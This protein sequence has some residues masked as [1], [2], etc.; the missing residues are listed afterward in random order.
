MDLNSNEKKIKT[1]V[2]VSCILVSFVIFTAVKSC[3]RQKSE[4]IVMPQ[5]QTTDTQ[6]V[7]KQ[8]GVSQNTAEKITKEIH[9]IQTGETQP[10]VTYYVTA[11]TVETAAEKVAADIKDGQPTVPKEA[12][13]KSDRTVV[14]ADKDHQKVDVYK[15]NLRKPHKIKVGAMTTG[16]KTYI[17]AGYQYGRWEGMLYTRTGKKVE[18]GSITYTIK[19]W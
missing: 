16:D 12:A 10:S 2:Y 7:K 14:T 13:Q 18:A 6:A 3:S 9:Y 19:E 11:P 17:G 1:I 15:V 4:P 8:L 5:E